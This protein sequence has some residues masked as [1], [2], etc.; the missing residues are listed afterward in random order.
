MTHFRILVLTVL[1]GISSFAL[2]QAR[3][4]EGTPVQ[5]SPAAKQFSQLDQGWSDAVRL[6]DADYLDQL[7]AKDFVEMNAGGEVLG[8]QR[9]IE[10][11]KTEQRHV[12]GIQLDNVQVLYASPT[13]A[14][15]SD[16]TTTTDSGSGT[17]SVSK[18]QTLRV[19]VKQQGRW[20]AAGAALTQLTIQ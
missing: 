19:F 20:R 12:K 1:L 9:Q 17:E 6:G 5:I 8:K 13:V 4:A 3:E 7:F 14:I 2:R 15:L 10:R 16:M 11:I 18:C